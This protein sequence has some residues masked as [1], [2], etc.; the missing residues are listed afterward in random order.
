MI[1]IVFVDTDPDTGIKTQPKTMATVFEIVYAKWI[2][3]ALNKTND[4]PNRE[5][6]YVER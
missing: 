2:C 3:Y 1:D 6:Y 4:E 5:I